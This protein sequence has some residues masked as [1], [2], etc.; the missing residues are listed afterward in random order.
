ML[1]RYRTVP[2]LETSAATQ[3]RV[4]EAGS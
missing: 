2:D 1:D 4:S 3:A